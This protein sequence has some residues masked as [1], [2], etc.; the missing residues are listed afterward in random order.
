M[1]METAAEI[2]TETASVI[3]G[4]L[5]PVRRMRHM[6]LAS[7]ATDGI[8]RPAAEMDPPMAPMGTDMAMAAGKAGKGRR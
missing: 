2:R 7:A 4:R 3:I 5:S 8:I 6:D 1:K